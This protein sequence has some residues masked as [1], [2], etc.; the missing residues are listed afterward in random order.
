MYVSYY[1]VP[2]KLNIFF[3]DCFA[4]RFRLKLIGSSDDKDSY[5]PL[6]LHHFKRN[7]WT[8]CTSCD[9]GNH[10]EV[11]NSEDISSLLI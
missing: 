9:Y 3:L 8:I 1:N 6:L 5:E 4:K 10:D 2:I 11:D 7:N